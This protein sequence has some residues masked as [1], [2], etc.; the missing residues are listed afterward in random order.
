MKIKIRNKKFKN[1]IKV[2]MEI[3][4]SLVKAVVLKYPYLK[5]KKYLPKKVYLVKNITKINM[6]ISY[7]ITVLRI[8]KNKNK[9]TSKT[10]M[11][12]FNKI[13]NNR[14]YKRIKENQVKD[15]LVKY[16]VKINLRY[17]QSKIIQ[18]HKKPLQ[19]AEYNLKKKKNQ[20]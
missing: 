4:L 10:I 1:S 16:K 11:K 7:Q 5:R 18:E 9:K 12:T 14:N 15:F 20:A 13:K 8:F 6:S 3:H 2:A 17:N 19:K